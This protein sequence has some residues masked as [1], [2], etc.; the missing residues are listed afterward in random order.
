LPVM[1]TPRWVQTKT[2]PIALDDA[3]VDLVGVR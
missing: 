1:I 2:Q 3:L